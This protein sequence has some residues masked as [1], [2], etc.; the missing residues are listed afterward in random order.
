RVGSWRPHVQLI[1]GAVERSREATPDGWPP[2]R[3]LIYIVERD[4][5]RER[6]HL[7]LSIMYREPKKNGDWGKLKVFRRTHFDPA[8]MPDPADR[9][10]LSLLRGARVLSYNYGY[11]MSG[12]GIESSYGLDAAMRRAILPLVC[13][14]GRCFLRE[15]PQATDLK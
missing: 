13:S 15:S 11:Y 12:A 9:E 6:E 10:V 4:R 5:S 3:Q 14:T 1:A 2:R 7:V 8:H